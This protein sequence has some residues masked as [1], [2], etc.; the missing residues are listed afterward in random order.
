MAPIFA[1]YLVWAFWLVSWLAAALWS[2]P[3]LK[4]GDLLQES[5][6]RVMAIAGF[7]LLFGFFVSRY[8]I[9]YRLWR[10]PTGILGWTMVALVVVCFAFCWWAR[11]Q[12]GSLWSGPITRKHDHRVV[13][14]GPYAIVRHPIYT[15]LTLC[16]IATAVV[17]GTPTS[18]IGAAL[19]TLCYYIK[20]LLEER[21][22]RQELGAQGYDAYS[23]RVPMFVPFLRWPADLRGERPRRG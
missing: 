11:I 17:Q 19:M 5:L 9:I 14:T 15:G 22:L 16:V 23:K 7:V 10:T 8:D 6:Y 21:F 12:L 4:R 1:I 18:F 2:G 13:E 3:A 20:A